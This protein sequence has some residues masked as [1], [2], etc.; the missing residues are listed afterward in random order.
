VGWK[1]ELMTTAV[2]PALRALLERF[3]D[4]AGMFPPAALPLDSTVANYDTYRAGDY[5]WM[6]RSLVVGAADMQKVPPS[7]NGCLAVLTET[8]ETRAASLETK[9]IVTAQRPVYCEVPAAKLQELDAVKQAGCFAKIR[10]GGLKPEAIPAPSDVAA[11]ICACAERRLPF[12]ATAGLHHPIRAMYP[13]TYDVE[14][15]RAVM[16]GF[17]NV[18]MA[19]AF[20]WHGERDIEPI[21]SETD[22]SAFSF[23]DRAHWRTKSLSMD[24]IRDTRLN[25]MHSVGSCSFDEPVRDLQALGLL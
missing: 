4:Y 18:L 12:K 19:S 21:I 23:A 3:I 17:L 20:A 25:F 1:I 2:S 14:A 22:S 10:T 15:P 8:D 7:L 13:L 11:F 5:S 9:G 6:L 24:E 16:H